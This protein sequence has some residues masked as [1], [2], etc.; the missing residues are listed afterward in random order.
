MKNHKKQVQKKYLRILNF[1]QTM[2]FIYVV[3][4]ELAMTIDHTKK[5]LLLKLLLLI[6]IN[7]LKF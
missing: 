5:I 1:S 7:L 4:E 3:F 6:Q 2:L